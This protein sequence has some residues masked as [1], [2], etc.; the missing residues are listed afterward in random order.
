MTRTSLS[1]TRR[2]IQGAFHL[3]IFLVHNAVLVPGIAFWALFL[4]FGGDI[5]AFMAFSDNLTSHYAAADTAARQDL[6]R[7]VGA[8]F[9][10]AFVFLATLRWP[11]LLSALGL[12]E[13]KKKTSGDS[14]GDGPG[15]GSGDYLGDD[16]G[17]GND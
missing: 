8:V 12:G 10:V 2:W 6:V 1:R 17:D 16:P 5:A 3:P 4:V 14:S 7:M 11:F 13:E 9:S 15:D